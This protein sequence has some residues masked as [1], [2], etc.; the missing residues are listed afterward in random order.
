VYQRNSPKRNFCQKIKN[1]KPAKKHKKASKKSA[2]APLSFF[3]VKLFKKSY[4][5]HSKTAIPCALRKTSISSEVER[6]IFT[7]RYP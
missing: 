4:R 1:P 2:I 5:R 7:L 6:N 3:G